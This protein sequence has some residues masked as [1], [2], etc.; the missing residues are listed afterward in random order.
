MEPNFE[1]PSLTQVIEL[2]DKQVFMNIELKVPYDKDIRS[3]YD[4]RGAVTKLNKQLQQYNLQEHCFV[5]SFDHHA[6]KELELVGESENYRIHTIYLTNFFNT[7][8]L[9]S[10]EE[11]LT[12]GDGLN[13]Q[14]THIT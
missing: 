14:Y 10:R 2:L 6:L 9:P 1:L 11:L 3:N 4:V 8:A 7:D 13:I 12:M 5:S